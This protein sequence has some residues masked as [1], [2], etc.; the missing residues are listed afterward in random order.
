[1]KVSLGLYSEFQGNLGCI[2]KNCLKKQNIRIDIS[3]K[4]KSHVSFEISIEN[5]FLW[6][7]LGTIPESSILGHKN[8]VSKI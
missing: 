5:M 4:N 8:I 2:V 1:M 6:L 3:N 7:P